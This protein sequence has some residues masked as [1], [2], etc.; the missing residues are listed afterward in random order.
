[1]Q[2]P[3]LH[4]V[5]EHGLGGLRMSE[6]RSIDTPDGRYRKLLRDDTGIL[7][8]AASA[9]DAATG[10]ASSELAGMDGQA[11]ESS[12]AEH[13]EVWGRWEMAA[14]EALN[15]GLEAA[16][17]SVIEYNGHQEWTAA[18]VA[19]AEARWGPL[20]LVAAMPLTPA[21]D[22]R[23]LAEA[24][25]SQVRHELVDEPYLANLIEVDPES[26]ADLA[27]DHA[28]IDGQPVLI[29]D[30]RMPRRLR[31]SY[32][33]D[34]TDAIWLNGHEGPVAA[35]RLISGTDD[36]GAGIGV[37]PLRTPEVLAQMVAQWAGRGPTFATV[38]A[39][40]LIDVEWQKQ[41]W[42]QLSNL[43]PTVA[44][45]DVEP[46]RLVKSWAKS[47]AP[48]SL[49]WVSVQ[50]KAGEWQALAVQPAGDKVLWVGIGDQITVNFIYYSL[51]G[52]I[53]TDEQSGFLAAWQ[54]ALRIV[55]THLLAIESY[56]DF[57]GLEGYV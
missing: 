47:G 2:S 55:L 16:G 36:G 8:A 1:M 17:A 3:V 29:V 15:N 50:D 51:L 45:I 53:E 41:W 38:A 25:L 24:M 40:C 22:D 54:E 7:S 42:S 19:A 52:A 12:K 39:S 18:V 43:L 33:W 4:W 49:G 6:L 23:S 35:V 32:R 11:E 28:R 34:D 56:L 57:A 37:L 14:Y 10:L 46:S 27:T 31:D 48:L 13:D 30:V 9:G 20:G 21:S 44:L 26:I 5:A